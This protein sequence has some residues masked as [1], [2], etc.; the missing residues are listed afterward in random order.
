MVD[1]TDPV[2]V[3]PAAQLSF[4]PFPKTPRVVKIKTAQSWKAPGIW[5]ISNRAE[6]TP[7]DANGTALITI[8][9]PFAG[10]DITLEEKEELRRSKRRETYHRKKDA[11]GRP[12]L[13]IAQDDC[14]KIGQVDCAWQEPD[15]T[16]LSDFDI[17]FLYSRHAEFQFRRNKR[18][19]DL[20]R[21]AL[22]IKS[23]FIGSHWP[24]S[25]PNG[26][27]YVAPSSVT[28]GGGEYFHSALDSLD[29]KGSIDEEVCVLLRRPE[30]SIRGFLALAKR[31]AEAA[32]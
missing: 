24:G 26:V 22:G 12:G 19:F 14:W 20:L 25:G 27:G 18:L 7:H 23:N 9:K 1:S 29:Q 3:A 6:A 11:E 13:R 21:N 4:P 16:S 31:E 15:N 2:V 5:L 28:N 8:G 17:D 10:I 30:T 32:W